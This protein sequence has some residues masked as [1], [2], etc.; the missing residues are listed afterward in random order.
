MDGAAEL[1]CVSI[2]G[3]LGPVLDEHSLFAWVTKYGCV[4]SISSSGDERYR[5]DIY[6]PSVDDHRRR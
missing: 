6:G 5:S 4:S 1:S 2:L 3:C